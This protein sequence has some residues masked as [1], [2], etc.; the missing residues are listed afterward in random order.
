[1]PME[2]QIDFRRI[3][4]HISAAEIVKLRHIDSQREIVRICMSISCIETKDSSGIDSKTLSVQSKMLCFFI[5]DSGI[6]FFAFYLSFHA[7]WFHDLSRT[8]FHIDS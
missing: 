8:D 1:M 6:E 2:T 3:Y 5:A 4:S 7:A